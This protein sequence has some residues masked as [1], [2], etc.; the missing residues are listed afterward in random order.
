MDNVSVDDTAR[1]VHVMF[2][3]TIP[4]CSMSTLIGLSIRVMLMRSL[5][6]NFK[7]R[8]SVAPGS[9]EQEHQL[10]KQLNDKERVS[11]ALEN[12][13]LV[14]V[15]EDCLYSPLVASAAA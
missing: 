8:L 13:T 1:I 14:R 10:N 3:P 11:A 7:I 4:Q 12:E 2:T 6:A 15:V 5:P 9:H